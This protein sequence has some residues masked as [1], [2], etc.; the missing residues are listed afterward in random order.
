[1]SLARSKPPS[2]TSA[3]GGGPPLSDAAL[4]ERVLR[5]DE[6]AFGTLVGRYAGALLRLAQVFARDRAVAEEAVQETWM[7]V[8]DG[9]ESFERRSSFKTWLF[10]ILSNRAKTRAQR[11]GRTVP[12]SALSNADPELEPSVD[13]ERFDSSGRWDDPPGEWEENTPERIV[14]RAETRTVL[15]QAMA[16]LPE[17]QRAV[18]TLRDLEGLETEDICNLLGITVT[19]QRVLL[20][21]ARSKVRRALERHLS[22]GR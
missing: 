22:K 17:A 20:H 18:L 12:F 5:G 13:P 2:S 1:M 6:A 3:G 8:L 19:N 15:E 4:V 11:E 9:L 16:E 10:R 14:L 21:R 7:A